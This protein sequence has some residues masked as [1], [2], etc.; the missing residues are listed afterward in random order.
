MNKE[1]QKKFIKKM[2]LCET[3]G[4][5]EVAHSEADDLLCKLLVKLGYHDIIVEYEKIQKWYA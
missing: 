2:Q 3:H 5:A 4:D 1:I